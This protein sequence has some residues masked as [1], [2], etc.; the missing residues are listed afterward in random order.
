[1]DLRVPMQ[2]KEVAH[3]G[4]PGI[5]DEIVKCALASRGIN[6]FLGCASWEIAVVVDEGSPTRHDQE[7]SVSI[8]SNSSSERPESALWVAKRRPRVV[9]NDVGDSVVHPTFDR[10][11]IEETGNRRGYN[12]LGAE[13]ASSIKSNL[14]QPSLIESDFFGGIGIRRISQ[15]GMRAGSLSAVLV[16]VDCTTHNVCEMCAKAS[17]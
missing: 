10:I 16:S 15:V 6:P 14:L 5:G 12:T 13:A 8:V 2:S 4:I 17:R 7:P 9:T 1:M 11:C 3:G